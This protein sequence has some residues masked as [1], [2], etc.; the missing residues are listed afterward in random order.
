MNAFACAALASLV[1]LLPIAYVWRRSR[2][3]PP[4]PTIKFEIFPA[5]TP[6]SGP[7]VVVTGG[8]GFVGRRI[9]ELLLQDARQYR[10]TVLDVLLPVAKHASVTYVRGDICDAKHVESAF[11]GA[12]AVLH[13]ASIIP[14]LK[15]QAS[16]VIQRVNVEGTRA[17]IDA[18]KVRPATALSLLAFRCICT[19]SP[20]LPLC[21]CQTCR[22]PRLIY[23][24]SATIVISPQDLDIRGI[25]ETA[26][27][28][29]VWHCL[30][31]QV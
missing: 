12:D 28:G 4:P 7:A 22:V 8:S 27:V 9:V 13:V 29:V 20:P 2:V 24:S 3:N 15:T 10:I 11:K 17:V 16:P 23:T 18:C 1:A 31:H 26:P 5:S 25:D 14:S 30:N 21:S 6:P 19:P